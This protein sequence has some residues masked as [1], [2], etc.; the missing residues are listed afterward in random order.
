[1][2][3]VVMAVGACS[4]DSKSDTTPGPVAVRAKRLS[5]TVTAADLVSPDNAM[6]TFE[7]PAR[8]IIQRKVQRVFEATVVKP[9]TTGIG[10]KLDNLFTQDAADHANVGDRAAMFDENQPRMSRVVPD[11]LEIQLT[12]LAGGDGSPVLVVAK[13]AWRVHS[14]DKSLRV[15]R[16][17]ELTFTSVFGDWFVSAYE[18]A[19]TRISGATSTTTT[20]VKE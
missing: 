15:E 16:E 4:G 5:L 12:A 20:A 14:P 3:A 7:H 19:V 2:L 11:Q 17:G 6:A 18:M 1:M 9:L 10:G 8:G 13:L